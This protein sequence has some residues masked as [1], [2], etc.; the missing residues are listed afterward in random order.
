MRN[1]WQAGCATAKPSALSSPECRRFLLGAR[2]RILRE[3]RPGDLVF[4]PGMRVRRL[5]DQWAFFDE[6]AVLAS[7]DTAAAAKERADA[8]READ[9]WI[10]G[11]Q[12]AGLVIVIEAPK[13]VLP[14]PPFRCSDWFNQGT[15][16][17]SPAAP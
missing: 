17:F 9:G 6:R 1:L 7:L 13:P 3:S 10:G 16:L 12:R 11:L 15:R 5:S 2:E 14:A 8:L 4:L